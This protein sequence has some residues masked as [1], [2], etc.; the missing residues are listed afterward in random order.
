MSKLKILKS[1]IILFCY[2]LITAAVLNSCK[3]TGSNLR[4]SNYRY[5]YEEQNFRIRSVN[6]ER[7]SECFNELIGDHFLAVDLNQD[8]IIDKIV[9]GTVDLAEAQKI[10]EFGLE[11]LAKE[12][13][14]E[15]NVTDIT[16]YVEKEPCCSYEIKS[17]HSGDADVF[18]EFILTENRDTDKTVITVAIDQESDGTL[19][20]IIK[21][22]AALEKLQKKYGS[23]IKTGLEANQMIKIN[24]A[25][26]VKR[27]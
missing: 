19:D 13:K 2:L 18:N 27:N 14:L 11:L 12:H 22:T 20:K 15:I 26:L 7:E 1:E 8:R 17:F 25:I 3:T 24:G 23:M 4:I 16:Q 6:C 9:M 10:Y 5:D 21:G